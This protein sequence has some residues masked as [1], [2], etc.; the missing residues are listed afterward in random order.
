MVSRHTVHARGRGNESSID[1]HANTKSDD[2][3]ACRVHAH[4]HVHSRHYKSTTASSGL[5]E[6]AV[7]MRDTTG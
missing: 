5:D 7:D 3:D 4:M 1:K 6:V 2:T